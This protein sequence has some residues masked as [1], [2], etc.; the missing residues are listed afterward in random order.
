MIVQSTK[1][2]VADWLRPKPEDHANWEPGHSVVAARAGPKK[3]YDQLGLLLQDRD[4]ADRAYPRRHIVS[5]GTAPQFL[6]QGIV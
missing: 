4:R 3:H 6:N 5:P 1:P 2:C